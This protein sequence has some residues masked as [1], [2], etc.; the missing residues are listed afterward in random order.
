MDNHDLKES[1]SK[2]RTGDKEAFRCVYNELKKPVFTGACR[3]V[4][5]SLTAEDITQDV[6]VK[7]YVAPPEPSV[8]N[9][10]AWIF[11]ITRNLSIDALRKKQSLSIDDIEL[12]PE[13]SLNNVA[14]RLDIE[15]AIRKLSVTERQI[16]ALHINGGLDLKI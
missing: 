15:A 11:Q 16:L 1:F 5:D 4:G 3:I 6:F 2:I 7:L 9:L 12:A 13:D 14:I 8:K 10:R